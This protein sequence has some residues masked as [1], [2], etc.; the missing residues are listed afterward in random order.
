[1]M[2]GPPGAAV[3][4]VGS[5]EGVGEDR[6]GGPGTGNSACRGDDASLLFIVL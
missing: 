5:V 6:T 3:H 4:R 2:I 1:M